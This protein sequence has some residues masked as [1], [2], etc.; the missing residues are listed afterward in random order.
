MRIPILIHAHLPRT[1]GT[2]L[3]DA[4]TQAL[5]PHVLR[6]DEFGPDTPQIVQ[7]ELEADPTLLAVSSHGIRGWLPDRIAGRE[8]ILVTALREPARQVVS[9]VTYLRQDYPRISRATRA[10]LGID[11][12]DG[13]PLDAF[14]A[15]LVDSFKEPVRSCRGLWF[16]PVAHFGYQN[17]AYRD[18]GAAAATIEHLRRFTVGGLAED[19]PGLAYRVSAR[20]DQQIPRPRVVNCQRN[21]DEAAAIASDPRLREFLETGIE[22]DRIVYRWSLGFS[23]LHG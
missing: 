19:L 10:Q 20:I 23:S 15:R 16:L 3:W 8:V 6:V 12:L 11:G 1:G 4:I 2:A 21:D 9:W 13:L 14:V 17:P 18:D 5:G 22:A 7:R